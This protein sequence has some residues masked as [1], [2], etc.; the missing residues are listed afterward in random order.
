[1]IRRIAGIVPA[2]GCLWVAFA[3]S[4]LS[5]QT[6]GGIAPDGSGGLP[7]VPNVPG[8]P[9]ISNTP[10]VPGTPPISNTPSVPGYPPISNTP[11]VPG[12]PPISNTPSVPGYPP[13]SNTPSDPTDPSNPTEPSDTADPTELSELSEL[14][15]TTELSD[16]SDTGGPF[17]NMSGFPLG[18][19]FGDDLLGGFSM[20]ATLTGTYDSN[21][22]RSS[23]PQADF[24]TSLGGNLSYLS[25]GI[26]FTFGA[27]YRGR[28]DQYFSMS[29]F[30]GYSQGGGLVANYKSGR[31]TATATAGYDSNRGSPQN[32]YSNSTFGGSPQGGNNQDFNQGDFNRVNMGAS[33]MVNYEGRKFSASLSAGI[34]LDQGS[35]NYSSSASSAVVENTRI[36]MGLSTRYRLNKDISLTGNI[37]QNSTTSTGGGYGD[38][39]YFS[40]G[41]SVLWRYSVLTEIGPG[42]RYTS[43][44][45]TYPSSIIPQQNRTSIG[46]TV[47]L[48]YKLSRKITLTSQTGIDFYQADN[49]QSIDPALSGSLAL[50][51]QASRL[52]G[53]SLAWS[54]GMQADPTSTGAFYESNS[55]RLGYHRK[56]RRATLNLGVSYL[57]STSAS[58]QGMA[59]GRP[60]SD[61]LNF[62]STLSM[63]VFANTC[64]ASVFVRYNEQS[65]VYTSSSASGTGN[66][67]DSLQMGFSI[68]RNF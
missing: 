35:N 11:S 65:G 8:Y 59:V 1:M 40:L 20:A 38:T 5:A 57:T 46:P 10:S 45:G 18:S 67:W 7:G 3:L 42:I 36:H 13:I 32:Y 24:F 44:S 26:P 43:M 61:S 58:P 53:M 56:I 33:V 29:D 6:N 9:P 2:T 39:S 50:N 68:N 64:N 51:Y 63:P 28:Y 22:T 34:D 49:G 16:T 66:S 47:T 23:Q 12:Y 37:D 19:A 14:S 62:D 31:I 21:I 41:T 27:N 52:W 54:R 30:S 48:N 55:L 4:R 60:D 15:D 17:D 25:K